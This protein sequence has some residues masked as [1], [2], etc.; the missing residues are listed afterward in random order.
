[1]LGKTMDRIVRRPARRFYDGF[2]ETAGI[3][4][5]MRISKCY[6]RVRYAGRAWTHRRMYV[7]ALTDLLREN[8]PAAPAREPTVIGDG[9]AMDTSRTLPHLDQLLEDAD[10]LIATRGGIKDP[11]RAYPDKPF[12]QT[13]L[14]PD[15]LDH[16]PSIL[17][18]VLSS[19]V[20]QTVAR[21]MKTIPVLSKTMP[22]GV[23]FVESN[24]AFEVETNPPYRSS[25]LYHLD[26][27][28]LPLVY[29]I[30]LLH[31]VT[32]RH[33]PWCF[34]PASASARAA[35]AIGYRRRRAPYRVSDEEMYRHVDPGEMIPFTGPRGAVLFIDSGACF[36]YGSRDCA[37]PRYMMMYAFTTPCR[38][39][40]TL[41]YMSGVRFPRC[42]GESRLRRLILA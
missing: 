27:H 34:L 26:I 11:K 40:M 33:G 1:M 16:H 3:A 23:R 37:L 2:M 28:D 42:A 13:L 12:F 5:T 10:G 38:T 36:H 25:Q 24:A 6:N 19:P 31:D 22:P 7:H 18:F 17:N 9:W 8:D 32:M 29:I 30:V 15:D 41:T 35:A 21:Y 20:I 4:N 14:R 39:D